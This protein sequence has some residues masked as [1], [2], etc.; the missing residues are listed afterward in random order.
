MP[1]ETFL[2]ADEPEPEV[3]QSHS[4]AQ[5]ML[6]W[7]MRW[8][9]PTVSS[10]QIYQFAPRPIRLDRENAIRVAETLVRYGWLTA[11]KTRQRNYRIW[12]ITRK[13]VIHPRVA[14]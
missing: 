3:K 1:N 12:E 8:P 11:L 7:L 10:C 4:D 2:F 6:D 13:P 5:K 14:E 9:K